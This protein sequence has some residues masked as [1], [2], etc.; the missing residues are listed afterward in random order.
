MNAT[1]I[2]RFAALGFSLVCAG[3]VQAQAPVISPLTGKP[4]TLTVPNATPAQLAA[5]EELVAAS[6]LASTF[7]QIVPALMGQISTNFS[8]TRPELT[9]D[10]KKT[11][12][13]LAPEFGKYPQEMVTSAARIY[14]AVMTEQQIK[15]A[16]TFF[17]SPSGKKF[18][19][20]QPTVFGNLGPIMQN[21][22][23]KISVAMMDR[24]REEMKKK[25]HDM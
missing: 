9:A 7:L 14:T 21:W 10:L 15:D 23:Q 11:L 16:V 13:E 18:V 24:V 22:R 6:G 20:S 12:D 5:A 1:R 8:Q 25:G 3:A 17:K 19:D 4:E 2:L